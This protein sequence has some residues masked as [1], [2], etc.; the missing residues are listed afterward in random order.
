MLLNNKDYIKAVRALA[1]WQRALNAKRAEALG[2]SV[3]FKREE[4]SISAAIMRLSDKF[5]AELLTA[6]AERDGIATS[7]TLLVWDD[8]DAENDQYIKGQNGNG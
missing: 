3:V 1:K 6:G 2:D 4:A 8:V 7:A 5:A